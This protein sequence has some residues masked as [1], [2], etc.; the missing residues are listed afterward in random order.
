MRLVSE[1][2]PNLAQ[3]AIP[4][5]NLKGRLVPQGRLEIRR[6][7]ILNNLQPSLRDLIMLHDGPRTS[8]LG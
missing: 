8:V 2:R 1:G 6:D 7:A 3:D 5:L 4:G